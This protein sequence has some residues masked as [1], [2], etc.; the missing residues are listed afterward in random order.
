MFTVLPLPLLLLE[1]VCLCVCDGA[2]AVR[3]VALSTE[4]LV[5]RVRTETA[6]GVAEYVSISSEISKRHMSAIR[7]PNSFPSSFHSRCTLRCVV[8]EKA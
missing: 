4:L 6:G 7:L 1:G 3:N 5:V 2:T 8:Y